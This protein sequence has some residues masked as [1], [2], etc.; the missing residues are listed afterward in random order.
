MLV[1][2]H[3]FRFF[4]LNLNMNAPTRGRFVREWGLEGA[5]AP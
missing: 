2:L 4:A 5:Q 1:K 3:F